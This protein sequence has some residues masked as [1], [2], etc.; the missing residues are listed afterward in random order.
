MFQREIVE[1]IKKNI[2]C[3]QYFFFEN[4]TFYV[5]MWKNI[6]ERGRPQM[7]IWFMRIACWIPRATNTHTD[8]VTLIAFPLQQWLHERAS[9]LRYIYIACH[10]F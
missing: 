10:V 9:M 8:C 5:I 3:F 4:R 7:T 2:L 6:V 1:K